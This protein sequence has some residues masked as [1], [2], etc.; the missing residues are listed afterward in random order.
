MENFFWSS[1][2]LEPTLFGVQNLFR[3]QK[4]VDPK[5]FLP[6]FFLDLIFLDPKTKK[7]FNQHFVDH[8][9]QTQNFFSPKISLKSFQ[10]VHFRLKSCCWYLCNPLCTPLYS[11]CSI[12]VHL[13]SRL[14]ITDK[15]GC[16]VSLMKPLTLIT[17]L[18]YF[19]GKLISIVATPH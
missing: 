15:I 9:F 12:I 17:W 16:R 18:R 19:N 10:A 11:I 7:K 6:K 4:F 5:F 3:T 8:F 13:L 2:F 1:H 14:Q